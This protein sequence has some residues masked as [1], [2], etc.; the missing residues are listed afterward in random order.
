M[1]IYIHTVGR[2]GAVTTQPLPFQAAP[3]QNRTVAQIGIHHCLTSKFPQW[4]GIR[5]QY[6]IVYTY[7][8]WDIYPMGLYG[9]ECTYNLNYIYTLYYGIPTML[10][11]NTLDSIYIYIYYIYNPIEQ[12]TNKG[13]STAQGAATSPN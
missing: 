9:I 7:F 8:L 2:F 11:P 6:W 13:L 12:S 3:R 10:I 1:Y 5:V 4:I